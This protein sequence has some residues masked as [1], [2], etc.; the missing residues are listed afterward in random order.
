MNHNH[1]LQLQIQTLK[2]IFQLLS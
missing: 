2:L 1:T